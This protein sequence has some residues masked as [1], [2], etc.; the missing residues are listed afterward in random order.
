MPLGLV[1]FPPRTTKPCRNVQLLD[2]KSRIETARELEADGIK[3]LNGKTFGDSQ[4]KKILTNITYTGSL[5]L[6]KEFVSDPIT[7][8]RKMNRGELPQYFV[9]DTHEPI[10]DRATFDFVQAEMARK[11]KLGAVGNPHIPTS[12][13]TSKVKCGNC[14][15]SFRR[16]TENSKYKVW[17]C[18]TK[19]DKGKAACDMKLIP[20][21]ALKATCA[22]VLGLAEFNEDAFT[23]RVETVTAYEGNILIFKLTDGTEVERVWEW[24]STARTDCWTPERRAAWSEQLKKRDKSGRWSPEARKKASELMKARHAE[25]PNWN[26]RRREE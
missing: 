16:R 3:T 4:L 23:E 21:P 14:G 19:D 13:L 24:H 1:G 2:G 20:E 22:E 8:K 12:A 7:K 15:K 18:A 11:R 5:L 25:N 17:K 9:E 10:I 6:Q 26:N